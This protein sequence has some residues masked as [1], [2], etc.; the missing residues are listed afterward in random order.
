M[1]M[2]TVETVIKQFLSSNAN[3]V[4]VLN[5]PW[6][7]GKTYTWNKLVQ[8]NKLKIRKNSYC[9]ISLFGVSSIADL[10]TAVFAKTLPV[11]RI[12]LPV[13]DK[14]V[15]E[16][17][18]SLL[19]KGRLFLEN[20][21]NFSDLPYAK[22][23]SV[24]IGSLSH[25]F[26]RDTIICFDDFERISSGV[27]H[28]ELLGLI[29]ELK[30][31]KNSKVVIILNEDELKD[32]E[33]YKK[34]REK[35]VDIELLFST[36][37]EEAAD[38]GLNGEL[39]CLESI[40]KYTVSLNIKNIRILR[41]IGELVEMLHKDVSSLHAG[42]MERAVKILVLFAWCHYDQNKENPSY[43]FIMDWIGKFWGS[44]KKVEDEGN[45]KHIIWAEMLQNYGL[46]DLNEF[47][48]AIFKVIKYG[49]IEDT[50][51][52]EEA[53]KLNN[54][55]IQDGLKDSFSSAWKLYRNTFTENSE[56]LICSLAKSLKESVHFVTPLS[57]NATVVLFRDLNRDD[58]ADELIDYFV[59]YRSGEYEVFS[60]K[61]EYF[62]GEITDPVLL[63]RFKEQCAVSRPTLT[64]LNAVS[65]IAKNHG[66]D[67]EHIEVI[68]NA[69]AQDFYDLFKLEHGDDLYRFVKV[70]LQF[71]GNEYLTVS[72]SVREA[73][74]RIGQESIL[75]ARR[76]RGYGIQLPDP[77]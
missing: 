58:I 46:L 47:D 2:A 41:K 65:F 71:E 22:Y 36:T 15:R 55:I 24:G 69:T 63:D 6:G 4:L 61:H 27:S 68:N 57:L 72:K 53:A 38:L 3:K 67:T 42:V 32:K 40:K 70:C 49:Y 26:L 14:S 5:G 74:I 16:Q 52:S 18:G 48:K 7:V 62:A 50:G 77:S 25:H 1:S 56:E 33:A 29:T 73:L 44:K 45:L 75:N 34:Y 20:I 54:V 21:K 37:A 12:G 39:H 30:E 11:A 17:C 13:D 59:K 31:E 23:F 64:L 43:E 76:V 60:L 66:W 51:F 10:H 35:V 19:G 9:Y 8:E 28:E